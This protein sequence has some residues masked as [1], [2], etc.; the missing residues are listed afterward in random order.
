MD[1]KKKEWIKKNWSGIALHCLPV[2]VW[3]FVVFTLLD[4]IS[5]FYYEDNMLLSIYAEILIFGELI[6]LTLGIIY[7]E[8]W[9]KKL[10]RYREDYNKHMEE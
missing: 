10:I 5:I 8:I 3:I 7:L 1:E 9:G 2:C 4:C 6:F